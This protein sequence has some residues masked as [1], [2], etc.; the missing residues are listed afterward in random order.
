MRFLAIITALLVALTQPIAA[1]SFKPDYDAGFKAYTQNDYAT[2]LKHFRPLAKQGDA[3]AQ[4]HLGLMYQH[5][6]GV[7]LDYPH[8]HKETVRCVNAGVKIHQWP[9]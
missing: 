5:G 9:E 2:A 3:K 8:N 7:I 4:F 1:Q 6:Y